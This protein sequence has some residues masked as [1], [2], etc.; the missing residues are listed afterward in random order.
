MHFSTR[1]IHA[2]AAIDAETGAIAPPIHLST[3]FE[4]TLEGEASHGYSYVRDGNPTQDRLEEALAVI[5][6]F[7]RW[8]ALGL[9]NLTN[10]FDPAMFVLGGGLAE[11]A[12]LYLGPIDRW[13]GELLYAPDHRPRPVIAFAEL[14]ERA[15]AIGAGLHAEFRTSQR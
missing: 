11:G 5:D 13:F 14:G 4:R 6:T 15:G 12:E 1:A 8:V 2:G 3:T 10:A 7:G 9:S